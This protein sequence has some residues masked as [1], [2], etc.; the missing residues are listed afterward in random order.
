MKQPSGY[1]LYA[2]PGLLDGAPIVCIATVKSRNTKTGKM[3]QTWILRQEVDPLE[4]NRKGLDVS[5]CGFCPARGN[6]VPEKT[7]GTAEDRGC[8]VQ[9]AQAP[10]SVWR[11]WRRGIYPE[12]AGHAAIA[13]VGRGRF[14]RLGAYGDQAAVPGYVAESLLSE[15]A[16]HTAYSHQSGAAGSSFD[17]RRFMVSADS[18][19]AAAAA[20]L[21][22][23]RT[24]RVVPDVAAIDRTREV[25]CPASAEA[26]RR[27]VCASCRLCGGSSVKA[28][29][30]AIPAHGGGKRAHVSAHT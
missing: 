14:V 18:R 28:K 15:S 5:V 30:V 4:A 13:A 22:G 11:S 17:G 2:G 23:Y 27:T 6:P 7:S 26:G 9:L 20:W 29:S 10:L 21:L 24:F 25:L 16:G 12:L 1:V 3:L 8:Y 19:D